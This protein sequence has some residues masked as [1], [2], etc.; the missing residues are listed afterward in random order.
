M[1]S[2]PGE[3]PS[4]LVGLVCCVM[5]VPD[6]GLQKGLPWLTVGS[7]HRLPLGFGSL[8]LSEA[9]HAGYGAV[10]NVLQRQ[11]ERV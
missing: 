4:L 1:P 7:V 8:V 2:L 5:K 9:A 3:R 10:L 11:D 6:K